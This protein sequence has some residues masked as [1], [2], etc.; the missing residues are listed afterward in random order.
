[1]ARIKLRFKSIRAARAFYAVRRARPNWS[2][3]ECMTWC[4]YRDQIRVKQI[5][6]PDFHL[7]FRFIPA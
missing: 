1:M 7:R 3:G 4:G 2:I 5:D 6:L